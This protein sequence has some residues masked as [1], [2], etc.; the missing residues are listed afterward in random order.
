MPQINGQQLLLGQGASLLCPP[1]VKIFREE[2]ENS[3]DGF[4]YIGSNSR[5]G[6]ESLQGIEEFLPVPSS[7]QVLSNRVELMLV[8]DYFLRLSDDLF[9]AVRILEVFWHLRSVS[10]LCDCHL[11]VG[12]NRPCCLP[13]A[14]RQR[15]HKSVDLI[16]T[17][18]VNSP[19]WLLSKIPSCDALFPASGSAPPGCGEVT[20]S[21]YPQQQQRGDSNVFP[22]PWSGLYQ[23]AWWDFLAHLNAR[24]N[25][26]PA[27]VSIAVAGPVAPPDT[28]SLQDLLNRASRDIFALAGQPQPLPPTTCPED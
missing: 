26:N 7:H 12:L 11:L 4:F 20:F 2:I 23:L 21:V 13:I 18:G 15:A 3:F 10:T 28:P 27:F 14:M 17:P 22:L 19:S 25:N 5:A 24:Y 1:V 6:F 16:I 9:D 8:S